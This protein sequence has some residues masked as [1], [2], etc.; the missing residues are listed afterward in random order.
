MILAGVGIEA[1]EPSLTLILLLVLIRALAELPH[2]QQGQRAQGWTGPGT[3]AEE[4]HRE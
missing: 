2:G 3:G 1:A 4:Q